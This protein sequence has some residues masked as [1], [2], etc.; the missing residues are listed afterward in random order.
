MKSEG[1]RAL[2]SESC[3]TES[4]LWLC[5]GRAE[6]KGTKTAQLLEE[7]VSG[8]DLGAGGVSDHV[9]TERK[10]P[11]GAERGELWLSEAAS[12]PGVA[13]ALI[14]CAILVTMFRRRRR[15]GVWKR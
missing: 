10:C 4:K 13:A 5:S 9:S 14:T 11:R 8:A 2:P 6:V 12:D 7:V 1:V 15:M 3:S